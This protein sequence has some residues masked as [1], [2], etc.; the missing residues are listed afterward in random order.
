MSRPRLLLLLFVSLGLALTYAWLETPRQQRVTKTAGSATKRQRFAVATQSQ[1]NLEEMGLDFS[2]GEKLA[3]KKPKRNLFRPL[4]EKPKVVAVVKVLPPPPEPVAAPVVLPPPPMTRPAALP[5]LAVKPIPPLTVL[6][7]LQK[8]RVQTVFLSS[9][10]GDIYVV[11]QGDRF[12]DGLLVRGLTAQEVRISR[13]LKDAGVTLPLGE[14]KAGRM[15]VGRPAP[16]RSK[17][18]G[19]YV[20]KMVPL[21]SPPPLPRGL[22]ATVGGKYKVDR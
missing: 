11:K 5:K 10:Q 12:A 20:P 9:M 3:Y 7:Y 15:P 8:N 13:G 17:T 21:S 4:Y 19:M 16:A 22:P 14:K 1:E 2:G 6:G 18:P